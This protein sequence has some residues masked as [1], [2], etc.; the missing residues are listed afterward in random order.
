MASWAQR[1]AAQTSATASAPAPSS[2]PVPAFITQTVPILGTPEVYERSFPFAGTRARSRS[3]GVRT[4]VGDLIRTT[5]VATATTVDS[6]PVWSG[7]QYDAASRRHH[8]PNSG[9]NWHVPTHPT[10]GPGHTMTLGSGG[11]LTDPRGRAHPAIPPALTS[12]SGKLVR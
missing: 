7:Y 11:S 6:A 8:H 4:P 2:A 1:V 10:P 5:E 3:V 9:S 12:N